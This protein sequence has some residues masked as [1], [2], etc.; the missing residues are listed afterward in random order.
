MQLTDQASSWSCKMQGDKIRQERQNETKNLCEG[1]RFHESFSP[2]AAASLDHDESLA[3]L[4]LE[5]HK[6]SK[7]SKGLSDPRLYSISGMD[8]YYIELYIQ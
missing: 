4:S 2:D 1:F 6:L 7:S 3:S 8:F 5:S